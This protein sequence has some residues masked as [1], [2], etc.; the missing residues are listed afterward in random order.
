VSEHSFNNVRFSNSGANER[1]TV[2]LRDVLRHPARRHVGD[3]GAG[4]L[5]QNVI[6]AESERVLLADIAARFIDNRKSISVR[7]RAETDACPSSPHLTARFR[8]ILFRRLRRV[9]EA[10]VRLGTHMG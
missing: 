6:D 8:E 7:I 5:T 2:S 4:A 10:A 9:S 1:H 3:H